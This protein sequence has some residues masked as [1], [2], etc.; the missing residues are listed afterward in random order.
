MAGAAEADTPHEWLLFIESR[1][2]ATFA[3]EV[4]ANCFHGCGVDT[5]LWR[6]SDSVSCYSAA[7]VL[8]QC[9]YSAA[10]VVPRSLYSQLPHLVTAL[11]KRVKCGPQI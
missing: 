9:C 3:F 8:L 11:T 10:T 5:K 6:C 1:R 4:R 2:N 7:T